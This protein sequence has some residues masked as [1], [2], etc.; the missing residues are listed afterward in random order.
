MGMSMNH[1]MVDRSIG[2][3]MV[4]TNDYL[5][6]WKRTAISLDQVL[7]DHQYQVRIHLFTN[8]YEEAAEWSLNHL[9]NLEVKTHKIKGWGWP[10]ATLLRY[11]FF[12]AAAKLIV[13]DVL[14][15]LDSDMDVRKNFLDELNPSAWKNGI[16]V[17]RHPGFV[18]PSGIEGF[19]TRLKSP[20]T[21]I[22]D[23][24]KIRSLISGFGGWETN[25][26]SEAYLPRKFRKTYVH[27]AIWFGLREPI[28]D[29]CRILSQRTQ[30]DL[31]NSVIA[32][33]HDESHLNWYAATTDVSFL[34]N[35][36]SGAPSYKHLDQWPSYV[37]SVYK[38]S[39]FGRE[40]TKKELN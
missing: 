27:G 7:K 14:I 13:E 5:T 22:Q 18:T 16:A 1:Q 8:L 6:L 9:Q 37:D 26:K 15:Y 3:L 2:V 40:A 34:D 21:M 33:W 30:T 28:L 24:K 32:C 4:A 23:L 29:L 12:S 35:R 19:R 20:S 25:Q 10:E 38:E 17:V 36:F 11:E 31:N 39:S